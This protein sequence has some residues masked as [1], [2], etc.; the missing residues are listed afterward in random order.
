[1]FYLW[2]VKPSLE[3]QAI[4]NDLPN[5]DYKLAQ[6]MTKSQQSCTESINFPCQANFSPHYFSELISSCSQLTARNLEVF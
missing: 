1:M 6:F 3:E 4:R 2:K 5:G